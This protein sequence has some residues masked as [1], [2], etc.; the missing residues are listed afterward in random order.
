MSCQL[1]MS[2]LHN[3]T[4]QGSNLRFLDV[5]VKTTDLIDYSASLGMYAVAITE[6]ESLS[7]HIKAMQHVKAR[8]EKGLTTP[9]LILGNEIYLIDDLE[10]IQE[11]VKAGEAKF[12][13][14]ILLAKDKVGHNQLR[15][16]SSKAWID[17]YFRQGLA[18]RVPTVKADL[19]EI[20]RDNPGHLILSTACIGGEL[21][22][23]ILHNNYDKAIEFINWGKNLFGADFYL[24][25]QPGQSE[26]QVKVNRAL[27]SL[28][29]ETQ[30]KLVVTCD[31]HYLREEDKALHLT[32]INSRDDSDQ[33]R[34]EFYESC[35]MHT[36]EQ[37]HEKMDWQIGEGAVSWA[38]ENTNEVADKVKEYDLAHTQVVPKLPVPDFKMEHSFAPVYDRCEYIKKFAY[39]ENIRD[40]YFL[41]LIEQGWWEKEYHEGISKEEM[42]KMM[43]RIDTELKAVW[44][45]SEKINDNVASYYI[46][47][48][49]LVNMMWDAGSLVGTARGSAA[50]FYVGYLIGMHQVNSLRYG[51][52]EWRHLHPSRP[53]MPDVDID[54]SASKR[55]AI[56]EATRQKFGAE[57][58]LNICTFKTEGPRSALLT[59]CR[60]MGIEPDIAQYLASL[61]PTVRG[62]TTPLSVMIN[63]DEETETPPN[64]QFINECNRYEGLLDKALSIEGLVSG[65]SI[66]A[67]GVI[68]FDPCYTDY[69]AAMRAPNGQPITQFD[70]NDSSYAGGLKFDFLTISN[71]DAIQSCI[72]LLLKYGYIEDKGSLRATYEYY[73][74][75]DKLDYTSPKMWDMI[76]NHEI[77]NLFQFMTA[78]GGQAISKIRPR[79]LN[80]IFTANA[81]MRLMA[82]EG[83]EQPLDRYV[84]YKN[85]PQLWYDCMRNQYHLTEDEIHTVEPYLKDFVGLSTMQET[86]MML[87]MDEHISGFDMLGANKLRKSIAKKKKKLQDQAKENFYTMGRERGTSENLL[88]YVWKEC[89]TPQLG[90][91]FSL[92]HI[93]GYS[94]IALLEANLAFRYPIEFWNC[95]NLST[96]AFAGED[97]SGTVDYGA[98]GIAISDMQRQGI[99]VSLPNINKSGDGFEPD[100]ENHTI[101]Y[102]LKSISGVGDSAVETIL[103]TRPYAS[104]DDFAE[105]VIEPKLLTNST[106]IALIQSGAFT[107]IDDKDPRKTLAKYISRYIYTPNESLTLANIAKIQA[108]NILP[109]DL[110]TQLHVYNYKAYVTQDDFVDR[111]IINEGK[112]VPK[113][114]Y[115]DRALVLDSLS[116][117]YFQEHFS[118]ESIIGTK[119][120]RYII[121]EK[122]FIKEWEGI[123]QDLRN[124][125]KSPDALDAFNKAQYEELWKKY[126]EGT[127]SR[128][129]ITRLSCYLHPHELADINLQPYGVVNY[130]NLPTQPE[131]YSGYRKKNK[132][133]GEW[134]WVPKFNITRLAGTVLNA[135]N[136]HHTVSI[137]TLQ[138]VVNIKFNKGQYAFYNRRMAGDNSW[139]K[140]GT[141]ILVCGYRQDDNFRAYRYNDTIYN[142][143]VN[144][145][146]GF[147]NDGT[148]ELMMQRPEA[149]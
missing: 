136:N 20:V 60:S 66:H 55:G 98:I 58:V 114:G 90:Y 79:N 71:L 116:Q 16:L 57:K 67:S 140:R 121:S 139:F 28:S 135:D 26:E 17:N 4:D 48:T 113:C 18:E 70:M 5:C 80:E 31:V 131:A 100:V 122:K 8:K 73:F 37:I 83:E 95:A 119:G 54:S 34:G 117:P 72:E 127:L 27:T 111:F 68:I 10:T 47:A 35:W 22:W 82:P 39:S 124:W 118:E 13:H 74:H 61:I 76:G 94:L 125:I 87:S 63:G 15:V 50:A 19:E 2:Q 130:F 138:G 134:I 43:D 40:R 93:V 86:V 88:N 149:D 78:V 105:R 12:F 30:T 75:P 137:L 24:E 128:Y 14:A 142:H 108:Y 32:F 115:H 59:C 85:N 29:K 9:K 129:E 120:D 53:E 96:M 23:H 62:A 141:L 110:N 38:I 99:N 91:S 42:T 46:T 133:T 143:T 101:L 6:H 49:D 3:H 97:L 92:P 33:E 132:D 65:R 7:S 144:K 81:I 21:P 109:D 146:I 104:F 145:I 56:I 148:L 77:V 51:I 103:S 44:I 84:R 126:G 69:N 147:K 41:H 107:A 1:S 112:K 102:G 123:T 106:I 64:M 89:I 36:P 45:S 11:R 52:P 25:V